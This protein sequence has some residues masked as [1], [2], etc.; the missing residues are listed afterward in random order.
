ML[1]AACILAL[2]LKN[3]VAQTA[4]LQE[5]DIIVGYN[6]NELTERGDLAS[7]LKMKYESNAFSTLK[8]LRKNSHDSF[9][10]LII[11]VPQRRN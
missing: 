4:G 7:I 10:E 8:V 5:G 9:T 2:Y 3:S 6:D 1:E 11:Q